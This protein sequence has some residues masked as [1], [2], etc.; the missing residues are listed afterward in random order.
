VLPP[1][2]VNVVHEM[3]TGAHCHQSGRGGRDGERSGGGLW[4][5]GSRNR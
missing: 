2:E 1:G 3:V 5:A 4:T